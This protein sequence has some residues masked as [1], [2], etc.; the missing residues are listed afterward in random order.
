MSFQ[1]PITAMTLQDVHAWAMEA[2]NTDYANAVKRYPNMTDGLVLSQIPADLPIIKQQLPLNGYQPSFARSEKA[3]K[4]TRRKIIAAVKNATGL[5][6]AAKERRARVDEWSALLSALEPHAV[7]SRGRCQ[8]APQMLIPVRKLADLARTD[9]IP[10]SI[11]SQDWLEDI[12][13]TLEGNEWKSLQRALKTLN[14]FRHDEA[15]ARFLP[16]DAFPAPP[17]RRSENLDVIPPHISS[18]INDWVREATQTEY[19][20]VE[21]E[22]VDAVSKSYVDFCLAAMRKFVSTLIRSGAISQDTDAHLSE[23]F[24]LENATA[25]VRFWSTHT[26]ENGHISART[27]YDYLKSIFVVMSR[28]GLDPLPMKN[29]LKANRFLK[30]G[31]RASG[32][33]SGSSRSFCE[34]LLGSTQLTITFLSLHV[35]LRN[36]A[37]EMLKEIKSSGRTPEAS[38]LQEI[39]QIGTVAAICAI[40]TRGAPIRIENALELI[41]RGPNPTFLLP[42]AKTKHAT[43]QLGIEETKND[44][45]IWAPI[46]PEN[47][48]GLEVVE[49][50]L[51]EIRPLFPDHEQ[52][53]YL[54]PTIIKPGALSYRTFLSWFKRYTRAEGLP[55]TPHKFRHGLASLLLERNPG[56]WD[57]LER[58]LDDT[59]A[60][61]RK[62]YAWVNERAQRV[63]VQKFILDLS[64][65]GQ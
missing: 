28:N 53:A 43:I 14:K 47:L 3:Y 25:V 51:R 10:P 57:L 15:V 7:T 40:E 63:E 22:F 35:K 55:M 11:V 19:D 33:M 59:P 65:I 31:K 29:H 37:N 27:A 64:D 46:N 61:V 42:T 2:G 6:S 60:T 13:P 62:N 36:R 1:K 38:E 24:T 8:P 4:A 26:E 5:A 17:K 23:L 32:E 34:Q 16:E 48:N 50:Y 30:G 56:R 52:S 49:W 54:F 41:F 58:L 9:G 44:V 39:R 21:Q 18:E 20:P 12:S 45:E